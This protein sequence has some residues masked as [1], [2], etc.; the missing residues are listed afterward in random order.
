[1][2]DNYINKPLNDISKFYPRGEFP[3]FEDLGVQKIDL[4]K[5]EELLNSDDKKTNDIVSTSKK[6]T[7][8]SQTKRK[9]NNVLKTLYYICE[10][11]FNHNL[12]NEKLTSNKLL[13]Y[14]DV[15]K[16]TLENWLEEASQLIKENA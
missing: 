9:L 12:G 11:K 10:D 13:E 6:D 14:S 2:N 15:S 16:Q 4:E 5:F 8:E 7:S 3:Q 1:M